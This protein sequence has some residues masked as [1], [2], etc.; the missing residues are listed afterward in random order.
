M[1]QRRRDRGVRRARVRPRSCARSTSSS[2]TAFLAM[3]LRAHGRTEL[4]YEFLNGYLEAGGDYAGVTCCGSTSCIA[5]WCARRSPPS[6]RRRTRRNPATTRLAPYLA[7]ALELRR[8]AHASARH[9][10]RPIGQRQDVRHRRAR[11]PRCRPCACAPTSSASACSASTP[12]RARGSA[13]GGGLYDAAATQRTYARARRD[14]GRGSCATA[15]TRSSTR[16]SCCAPSGSSSAQ[17]AAATRRAV[18]DPRLHGPGE[19]APQPRRGARAARARRV[20]GR[21]RRARAPAAHAGTAR[22]ARNGAPRVRVATDRDL[23]ADAV[24]ASL[25]NVDRAPAQARRRR[26][27]RARERSLNGRPR[28]LERAPRPRAPDRP[29]GSPTSRGSLCT[30][31]TMN[32]DCRKSDPATTGPDDAARGRAARSCPCATS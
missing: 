4:G 12:A 24:L 31:T 17:V 16:R 23:D 21:S 14:R 30:T 25:A 20:G 10:A 8:T 3:D 9:H 11:R 19:R 5:R 1:L 26:R 32:E 7:T 28:A 15:S 6:K 2:E 18:R 22:A 29:L 27:R 13:V